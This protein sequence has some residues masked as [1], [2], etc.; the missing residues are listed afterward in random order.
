MSTETLTSKEDLEKVIRKA[1]IE[2]YVMKAYDYPLDTAITAYETSEGRDQFLTQFRSSL[3]R[4]Y[5]ASGES[6]QPAVLDIAEADELQEDVEELVQEEKTEL[7]QLGATPVAE[8]LEPDTTREGV[9]KG[10]S[11]SPAEELEAVDEGATTDLSQAE[12]T[13]VPAI[14]Q[15]TL[16]TSSPTDAW[17]DV[18]ITDIKIKFAVSFPQ[19]FSSTLHSKLTP[20]QG[21]QTRNPTHRPTFP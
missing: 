11:E 4:A 14:L 1:L 12:S 9:E 16:A 5:F 15:E 6:G 8:V 20:I 18:S 19:P 7:E 21:P 2:V 13:S 3:E 10:A 17:R